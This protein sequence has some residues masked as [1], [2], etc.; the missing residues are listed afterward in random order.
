MN[1]KPIPISEIA[2][3]SPFADAATHPVD[4]LSEGV[5]DTGDIP[6]NAETAEEA[7]PLQPRTG[8]TRKPFGATELKLAYPKRDGYVRHWFNDTPGRIARAKEAG[9]DHVLDAQKRSVSRSVGTAKRGGGL[10]A[11]LMEIPEAFYNED[12]ARKQS[13]LD[14]I[15]KSIYRGQLNQETG[16]NRYVPKSTP[17][18]IRVQRGPGTG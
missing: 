4:I 1:R 2:S 18:N 8:A 7:A 13:A 5:G 15:D 6:S 3:D 9:Y 16:D 11:F 10:G 17:I 14:E 12:F